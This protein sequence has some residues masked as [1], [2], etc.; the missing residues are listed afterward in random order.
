M[1]SLLPVAQLVGEIN[2]ITA[3]F[4]ELDKSTVQTILTT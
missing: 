4:E 2:N 1:L 3:S